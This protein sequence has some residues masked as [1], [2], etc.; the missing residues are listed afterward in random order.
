MRFSAFP[1]RLL[2]VAALLLPAFA[3]AGNDDDL[4]AARDAYRANNLSRLQAIADAMP[5]SYPLKD[6]PAYWLTLKALDQDNDAQVARFLSSVK[7]GLLPERI[8]NEWLKKLG[9][10][11]NWSAFAA[12]WKK[13]P[14]EGRD[15]ESACYGQ[16]LDMQSG[17][18]PDNLDRFLD[19]RPAP[20]G[21]NTLMATA[22]AKGYVNQDWLWRRVRLL[23]AGN[24]VTQARA[25]ADAGN[26]PL[27]NAA[28]NKPASANPATPGGQ[29]AIVY[30]IVRKGRTDLNAASS[31]LVNTEAS[32]S[33]DRR[34]F[35]WGQLA[36]YSARKQMPAQ[37]LQWFAKADPQQLTAEQ[38][39]WWARSAL[40][41]EQWQKLDEIIGAMPA[42]V[43]G[44]PAWQYWRG[45]SLK[46]MGK[47]NEA[48]T[49]FARA[50][51][52]HA[53]YNLLALEEL[54][55][56]MSAPAAKGTPSGDDI[57]GMKNDPSVKRAL[58]LFSVSQRFGKPELRTDA[59]REWR[60]GMRGRNDMQLLAAAEIGRR[61]EFF[62]MAIYSAERTKEEHDFSLRYLTPYRDVTRRYAGEIGVDDAWV[63][64]LIRQESRFIVVAR[65]GVGASGLMQ[66]MPATASWVAKKIGLTRYQVNDI[67]TNVQMGTWYLKYVKDNLMGN[68]VMATAA[69]NA[70]PARARAWQDSR[71]L[72]GTI[73]AETIPFSETR[74]YVQK[75]MANAAFYASSFGHANLSLKARMG[76]V[77]AR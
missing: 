31:T 24:F 76:T 67:D 61:E 16:L 46:Q 32:L 56:A 45:R 68:E 77:P 27:D 48:T 28:L 5:A 9:K 22:Y 38:W 10:R 8:R 7:E 35:A 51:V 12:E 3:L 21:C 41:G 43:A 65:S 33:K 50:S 36:L 75:V 59:T 55:N 71:P 69:Y 63:Y 37:S 42:E 58:A 39:E 72:D 57:N 1:H 70:G 4:V 73:Y 15:D 64:G 34:G 30:D 13:L 40:R 20:E 52:G 25:L 2:P 14:D 17:K 62:D 74:D 49:L 26:L 19:S 53:Y 23:L 54:G 60:W 44:K 66:L 6:Y 11:E 47:P 18:K 29:E